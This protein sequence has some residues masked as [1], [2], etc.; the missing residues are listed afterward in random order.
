M[1]KNQKD[2]DDEKAKEQEQKQALFE[3]TNRVNE[4]L[5][6]KLQKEQELATLNEAVDDVIQNVNN[7][8]GA[9]KEAKNGRKTMEAAAADQKRKKSEFAKEKEAL[10]EENNLLERKVYHF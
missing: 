5:S 8:E 9:F 7:M 1:S 4:V 3:L 10:E 6:L 2:F